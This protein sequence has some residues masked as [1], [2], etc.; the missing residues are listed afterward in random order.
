MN[1]AKSFCWRMIPGY[2]R[3]RIVVRNSQFESKAIDTTRRLNASRAGDD[4]EMYYQ[5]NKPEPDL[6]SEV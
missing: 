6:T 4:L 2:S 1:E 5:E 3:R